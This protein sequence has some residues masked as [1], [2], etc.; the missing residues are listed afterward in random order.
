[1]IG[2]NFKEMATTKYWSIVYHQNHLDAGHFYRFVA[3][4]S[5][6]TEKNAI[7]IDEKES[8][9]VE[10]T[11][12]LKTALTDPADTRIVDDR[13]TRYNFS[14]NLWVSQY[15]NPEVTKEVPS[16]DHI[17]YED[18]IAMRDRLI[19]SARFRKKMRDCSEGFA[20]VLDSYIDELNNLGIA[21]G[22]DVVFP[23]QPWASTVK[24]NFETGFEDIENKKRG[25][26]FVN[27]PN[28]TPR[29]SAEGYVNG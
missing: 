22:R 4:V 15:V 17:S 8:V 13:L 5:T 29:F 3:N 21:T 14:T 19:K 18:E 26:D 28:V 11:G 7:A 20:I 10:V 6:T 12:D 25:M 16:P 1:L 24:S 2:G 27:D 23:P 9:W